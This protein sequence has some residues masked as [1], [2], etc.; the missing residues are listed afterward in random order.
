MQPNQ[1][2]KVRSWIDENRE[3]TGFVMMCHHNFD[4][5]APRAK[6]SLG[7][8]WRERNVSIM[9]TG[10]THRG[11]FMH[12]DLG[13]DGD[14]LELNLASTTDWPM[15]W[16]TLVAYANPEKQ[17]VYIRTDRHTLVEELTNR[18]GFFLQGWEVPLDAPDDYRKYKQG[19]AASGKLLDI[20]YAYAIVPYW[21]P[22][23]RVRAGR[24]ARRT[25]EQVK[26]TLL[27]TYVRLIEGFPTHLEIGRAAWPE[28]C[29][30][31][32]AVTDRI[33]ALAAQQDVLT[34]KSDLLA[35]LEA[36][37]RTRSTWDPASS[38]PTDDVRRRFKISQAA[39][40]SR[41]ENSLGRQLSVEDE[42]IR[43]DWDKAFQR[44]NRR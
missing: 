8:V 33:R 7:W 6:S 11:F 26:D 39:W 37:E 44:R 41:F 30:T 36:F 28:G 15:E 19:T 40:A 1:L 42:L 12:H 13:G 24:A 17:Q 31:D 43:V 10:H 34:Q 21:M 25:E 23:P 16:R 4:S 35:E 14:E 5:L 22:Q 38:E 20:Y 27:W 9:V 2:R 29:A 32:A 18:E 3:G